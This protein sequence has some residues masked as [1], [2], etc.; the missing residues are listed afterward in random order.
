MTSHWQ[1]FLWVGMA[2]FALTATATAA[3]SDWAHYRGPDFDGIVKTGKI[4]RD[5]LKEVW[6]ASV[7][8]GF[9]SI[10]VV[11]GVAYTMGNLDGQD[12]IVAL[13]AKTGK[14]KWKHTYPCALD[15]NLY[16]GGPNATPTYDNGKIYTLSKEGHIFCLDAE[17][18]KVIW[19]T[20]AKKFSNAPTWGYSGAATIYKDSVIFNV[21]SYGLALNKNDGK[22][23]WKSPKGKV[24]Y[25]TPVPFKR[26]GEDVLAMFAGTELVL[27][28]AANGKPIWRFKW[29]T[30]YDVNAA[31]PIIFDDKVLITSGYRHGAT[32]LAFNEENPKQ[33]WENDDLKAQFNSPV[34]YK[35]HVYGISGDANRRCKLVCMDPN[36]GEV[37]WQKSARF[38]SLLVADD[39]LVVLDERGNLSFVAAKPDAYE[40]LA[41]KAVL[42]ARSWTVPTI[43]DGFMYLRDAQGT[44][45]CLDLR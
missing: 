5:N 2:A 20:H 25:A 11:K 9:S 35:G 37:K 17:T 33:I 45:V 22:V 19:E 18:G 24:G 32:L 31:A 36:T 16:E 42:T 10:I 39:Q 1:S 3:D 40:L 7:G 30:E 13:D 12:Q 43:A 23:V 21:G 14:E 41:E 6:Q 27:V 4:N 26:K 8:T 34:L 28:K 38:G 29:I 15:P 44:V